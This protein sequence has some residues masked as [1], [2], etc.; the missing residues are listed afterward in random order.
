MAGL[1]LRVDGHVR[2]KLM[3]ESIFSIPPTAALGQHW[4]QKKKS[5]AAEKQPTVAQCDAIPESQIS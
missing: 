5:A 4:V 3:I 2:G 1:L